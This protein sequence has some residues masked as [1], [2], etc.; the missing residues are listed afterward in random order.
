MSCRPGVA[1]GGRLVD[2]VVLG[3][4]VGR[5]SLTV[6]RSR[7]PLAGGEGSISGV[8]VGEATVEMLDD[9]QRMGSSIQNVVVGVGLGAWEVVVVVE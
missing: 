2:A 9:M 1:V 4:C 8:M 7:A 3:G 5:G 6:H